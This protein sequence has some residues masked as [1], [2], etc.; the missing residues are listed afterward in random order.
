MNK[1]FHNDV[2]FVEAHKQRGIILALDEYIRLHC[3]DRLREVILDRYIW[4]YE[5]NEDYY[6]T[7]MAETI[8]DIN[9]MTKC[10]PHT[11]DRV[12]KRWPDMV[13]DNYTPRIKFFL[14]EIIIEYRPYCHTD[15]H[16]LAL[17]LAELH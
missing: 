6:K 7:F 13:K 4:A 15:T 5:L 17:L 11:F 2:D 12:Q 16:N 3:D 1:Y 9:E 8:A 14:S 10:R